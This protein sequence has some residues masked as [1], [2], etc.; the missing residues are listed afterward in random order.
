L[1]NAKQRIHQSLTNVGLNSSHHPKIV[2]DQR[3]VWTHRNI[4]WVWIGVEE[5][6]I[7]QLT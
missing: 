3:T 1:G 7:K 5:A 6:M 4:T 2:E